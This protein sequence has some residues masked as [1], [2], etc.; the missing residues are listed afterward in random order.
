MAPQGQRTLNESATPGTFRLV[1]HDGR[2]ATLKP[3]YRA[4]QE[5]MIFGESY[6]FDELI[7]LIGEIQ[8]RFNT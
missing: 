7:T 5:N 8:A 3:D 6:E 1:P 4:M 2:Y